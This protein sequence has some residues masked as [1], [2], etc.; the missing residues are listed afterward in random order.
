MQH[1]SIN[2]RL[3]NYVG[4]LPWNFEKEGK[5]INVRVEGQLTFNSSEHI[6]RAALAGLRLT[7]LPESMVLGHVKQ[8]R[9][10]RVLEDWCQPFS[11][12][13]MYYPSR[14]QSSLTFGLIVDALRYRA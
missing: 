14:R 13:H 12:Y 3:P 8:N 6:V 5:A 2:L 11:G 7:W 4:V 10:K 9:L 1:T